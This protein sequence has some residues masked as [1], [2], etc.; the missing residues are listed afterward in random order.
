[1][2]SDALTEDWQ[3]YL[4][5]ALISSTFEVLHSSGDFLLQ[6]GYLANNKRDRL[7]VA[8]LHGLIYTLPFALFL[9]SLPP[10]MRP[11]NLELKLAIIC[12]THIAIDHWAIASWWC[13]L[14]NLDFDT[15]PKNMCTPTWVIIECDQAFHRL[16]NHTALW[17]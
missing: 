11:K 17:F 4:R 2:N 5:I 8:C 15:T 12:L 9:Y 14:Y 6:N 10:F 3:K 13:R 7:E 1:M 16:I